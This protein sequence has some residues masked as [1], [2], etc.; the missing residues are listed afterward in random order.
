G[1]HAASADRRERIDAFRTG[2][3]PVLVATTLLERG[4]TFDRLDV[5]VLDADADLFAAPA[6]IQMAG[7]VDRRATDGGGEV[8]FLSG[9]RTPA[10]KRARAQIERLNRLAAERGYLVG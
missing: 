6:L 7:R 1:V 4:V 8:W 10:M 2:R 3:I 5:A 9:R